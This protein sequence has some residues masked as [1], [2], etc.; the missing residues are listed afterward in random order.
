MEVSLFNIP[1]SVEDDFYRYK[2]HELILEYEGRGKN[3]K[4]IL[5]NIHVIAKELDRSVD[6]I[7]KC[8]SICTGVRAMLNDTTHRYILMG[9]HIKEDL[10]NIIDKIIASY[11]LCRYCSNP[12]TMMYVK[13]TKLCLK[14][15]ACG[16]RSNIKCKSKLDDFVCTYITNQPKPKIIT[17]QIIMRHIEIPHDDQDTKESITLVMSESDDSDEKWSVD[18]SDA[19]VALR[20]KELVSTTSIVIQALLNDY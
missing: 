1:R 20:K 6:L 10:L 4:T 5:L 2:M 9:M 12:E 7:V 18:V 19:A 8:L 3:T 17:R 14:C 13:N 16:L 11:V 15:A